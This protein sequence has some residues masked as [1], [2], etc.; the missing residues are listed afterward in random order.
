MKALHPKKIL[1]IALTLLLITGSV[2]W[3]V[4]VSKAED[5]KKAAASQA[6]TPAKPS[7][8][9]TTIQPETADWP[10]TLGATG[11]IEAWQEAIIGSEADSLRLVEVNVNVGD[12]VRCGQVL[13][14]FANVS[15]KADLA[16][17]QAAVAEAEAAL[18]QAK[19]NA[20]RTRKVQSPGVISEQQIKEYRTTEQAA[21]AR[22]EAARAQLSRQRIRLEQTQLIAPD[23]GLISSRSATVGA[24]VGVGQELFRLIR[25]N[26]LEWRAEVTA[27]ELP[28]LQPGIPAIITGPG[29]IELSGVVR[30]VAPTVDPKKRTAVVYVDIPSDKGLK[31][32]MFARGR[33]ALGQRQALILP[34]SAVVPREGF[35]YI[36]TVGAANKV[37]QTKVELGRRLGDAV[38][39]ISTLDPHAQVVATGAAFLADG[40]T[41]RVAE[42]A[43]GQPGSKP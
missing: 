18:S 30:M 10:I 12:T 37:T 22:V 1:S 15:V 3:R 8:T 36:Y 17:A 42:A 24:V 13:A 39:I 41:V 25:M 14:A 40:D 26:R 27:E 43:E 4:V 32:G 20:D 2:W 35:A 38:E 5:A 9:V 31:A 33:F 23:D 19:A 34:Q 11:N 6:A 29:E 28:S 16:Q 7:L 21:Q